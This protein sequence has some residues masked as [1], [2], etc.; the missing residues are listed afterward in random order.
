MLA[1]AQEE[2]E[3]G[4]RS[5]NLL[6]RRNPKSGWANKELSNSWAEP[7]VDHDQAQMPRAYPLPPN[8]NQ[9]PFQE[10]TNPKRI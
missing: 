6:G 9:Y 1:K 2:M 8:E 3:N 10:K 5:V 4:G 7:W